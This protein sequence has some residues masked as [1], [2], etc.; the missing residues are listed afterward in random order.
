MLLINQERFMLHGKIQGHASEVVQIRGPIGG[1]C[2]ASPGGVILN[3][4][5]M[6][7]MR[8]TSV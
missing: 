5:L 6:H 1:T 8:Q 3:E 2:I 4:C 7:L